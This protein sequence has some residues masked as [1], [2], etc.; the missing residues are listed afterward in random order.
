MLEDM[1]IRLTVTVVIISL[2]VCMS[3]RHVVR[4]KIQTTFILKNLERAFT[5][6]DHFTFSS[7]LPHFTLFRSWSPVLNIVYVL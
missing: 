5:R 3:D 2:C 6:S 7:L 1:L 4:S